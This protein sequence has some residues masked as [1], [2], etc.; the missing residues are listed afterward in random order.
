MNLLLLATLATATPVFTER[1]DTLSGLFKDRVVAPKGGPLGTYEVANGVITFVVEERTRRFTSIERKVELRGVDWLKVSARVTLS[2]VGT[3]PPGA[4]CGLFVRFDTGEVVPSRPCNNRTEGES[5]H[6]WV[7]VPKGA[8][9]A[10]VGVMMSA[11]GTLVVD[12]VV[13]DTAPPDLKTLVRGSF[14]YHWLGADSFRDDQTELNESIWQGALGFLGG[15]TN[16]T[17][18]YWKYPDAATLE[19][20][21]GQAGAA[22]T[23]PTDV[24][25]VLKTDARAL[26]IAAAST[27]GTPGPLLTEG[28]A[29]HLAGDWEGRDTRL[30]TRTQVNEGRATTLATLL[31]AS[32]FAGEAP[33]RAFPM[34]GAFVSWVATQKGADTLLAL[35][36]GLSADGTTAQNQA[37]LERVLAQPLPAI[38]AAFRASL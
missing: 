1:F 7:A 12:D 31:S 6:R 36:S 30:T 8:R 5:H 22:W 16:R 28:L 21:T 33:E 23:T 19:T 29:I 32:S 37:V 35:Y 25:S 4:V 26:V 2:G 34:A 20:F 3:P 11:P 18:H 15:P 38:E 17:I 14:E 10:W 13:A 27:Q 24:H 9:D